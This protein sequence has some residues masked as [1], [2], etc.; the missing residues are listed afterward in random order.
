MAFEFSLRSRFVQ[1]VR[2]KATWDTLPQQQ[3]LQD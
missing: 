3:E 2:S 1:L